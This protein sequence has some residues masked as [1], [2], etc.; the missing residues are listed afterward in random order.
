[1]KKTVKILIILVVFVIIS[2]III[3]VILRNKQ[4]VVCIDAGHGG[5]DVGAYLDKR[6]EKEDTLRIAKL[7]K[8][9][10]EEQDIKVILTRD[11]DEAVS[12]GKRCKIANK[13]LADVFVSLH[14]NSSED[15]QANGIEIWTNSQKANDDIELA[16]SI[17][18]E[19]EKTEIQSNRGIK[20]GSI[21]GEN[22]NYYVLNNTNM[23]SCLIELG[24]ISN[25]EDNKLLD[26]NIEAYAKAIAN[27]IL[28]K[29]E[30]EE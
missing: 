9:Y 4:T 30:V 13:K 11:S 29:L 6:Y 28:E 23:P 8:Q 22:T 2:V 26:E 3:N 25:E 20:N 21:K 14:R 5:N 17:L 10:L 16:E 15:A 18:D 7:V 19:L 27:G 12:L 1:M 24:F